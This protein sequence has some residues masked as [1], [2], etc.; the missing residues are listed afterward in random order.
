MLLD[1]RNL[2][3]AIKTQNG[4]LRAV[5]GVD[6]KLAEGE[7]LGLVG[8]SGCGKSVSTMGLLD[9]LPKAATR[10][11][12]RIIF[13]GQDLTTAT[14]RQMRAIRGNS[15]G[16]IFQD[17][18]TALNPTYSI[19]NQLCEV[20]LRHRSA[21]RREAEERALYL[22]DRVGITAARSRL[23]QYPHQLSGGLRQ[24]IVI[25]QA[26]M[27]RPKLIIA[28][29]PTTALDVTIQIQILRLIKDIQKEMNAGVI[30]IT[31]DLGVVAQM[32]DR[33]SVMYAGSVVESGTAGE[34]FVAPRHPYTRALMT[35]IPGVDKSRRLGRIPGIVP[36]LL[37][38][39]EG[40]AFRTRCFLATEPCRHE[41]PRHTSGDGHAWYCTSDQLR[42]ETAP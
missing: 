11:A 7:V 13:D 4:I 20:Y 21:S 6:L 12:E 26:L 2:A 28:D 36:S 30:L 19:G 35:C 41:I 10:T 17:P 33:V 38:G 16:V 8:E 9:L 31:H 14:D 18:M 1:V 32:A 5:R 34:V 37:G 15:I 40:C 42:S 22:L 25:A 29:E 23:S 24:R 39:L 3:V 27:C